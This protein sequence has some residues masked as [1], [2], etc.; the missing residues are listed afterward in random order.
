[1]N[2]LDLISARPWRKAVFTTYSL[3]LAFF[4]AVVLDAMV[5]GGGRE[6]I[7]LSDV[8]GVRAAL[9]E[10]GA[11]RVGR[12]YQVEPVKAEFGVFHPKLSLLLHDDD[13]HLLVGS[14]NLTFGGWE[15]EL[16]GLRTHPCELRGRRDRRRRRFL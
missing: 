13:C 7:I 4:E 16:R 6:A 1:M 9:M 2:Q 10:Q 8:A 15:R 5:R 14:G 3:S 12:D 11:R